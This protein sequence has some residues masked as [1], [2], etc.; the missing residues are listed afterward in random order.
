MRSR[1]LV[2]LLAGAIGGF[3][4][5]LL[6]E[7]LIDYN[8]TVV[9]GVLHGQGKLETGLSAQQ[10]WIL[11]LCVGGMIGLFLGMV[12]GVV[13]GMPRKL[14]TGMASGALAGVFL[15]SIGFSLGNVLYD[16][17]RGASSGAE[18]GGAL[19]F[20]RQV[21][22]RTFGWAL[23]GLGLGVGAAVGTL[24]RR[25]IFHGAIGGFLGG[26]IGGFAFDL[27]ALGT[28]SVQTAGT[29]WH[30]IGGP[31]RL[32]GFTAIG[33][34][35]GFFIGLVDELFKQAWVK[36]LVG[37]NEGREFILSGTVNILGRDERCD[38]PLYGDNT[39]G[40][41]HAAIRSDGYRSVVIDAGTPGG[42][43]V[44]GQRVAPSGEAFLHDGDV[45]QIGVHQILFR[46][47][48]TANGARKAPVD[49]PRAQSPNPAAYV[50]PNICPFCGSPKDAGGGCLCTVS[51][52]G[53]AAAG[54]YLQA[55][56]STYQPVGYGG[57]AAGGASYPEAIGG[58]RLVGLEGAYAG[59][60]IPLLGPN[61]T[62]GREPERDI[63]LPA[64]GTVS[65]NHA[66]IAAEVSGFVVHDAG[67]VNGTFVNGARIAAQ[68]IVPGDVVQFGN[69]KFRFDG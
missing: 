19:S 48:A 16:T 64:D 57:I 26:F 38:V 31:S 11:V 53:A 3:L 37:R 34:L 15:G 50:P 22:A 52:P 14:V 35:A 4:G 51:S 55:S 59:Q 46:E 32:V 36:V 44:N 65:R 24:N 29:G 39:V 40:A 62:V 23:V 12:D 8:A 54:G 7:H 18:L 47:K 67:S 9:Q 2:G 49:Q 58:P 42:T 1:I 30:D 28:Q 27:L 13:Q 60:V 43:A 25:R 45:I 63:A 33:G 6:Q 5:W 20:A 69:S 56:G 61:L 66:W 10:G 17:I 68:A 41:Q 21:L